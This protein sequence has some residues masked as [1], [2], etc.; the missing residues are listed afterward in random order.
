M[1]QSAAPVVHD[2]S[3]ALLVTSL[4]VQGG[5]AAIGDEKTAFVRIVMSGVRLENMRLSSDTTPKRQAAVLKL[6]VADELTTSLREIM[7]LWARSTPTPVVPAR[8]MWSWTSDSPPG[9]DILVT[10]VRAG[11]EEVRTA[12]HTTPIVRLDF[13]G[14]LLKALTSD[15]PPIRVPSAVFTVPRHVQSLISSLKKCSAALKDPPELRFLG[16]SVPDL[17]APPGSFQPAWQQLGA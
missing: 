8:G 10:K 6:G 4:S 5:E 9:D 7:S 12:E 2:A 13:V 3:P 15:V 11:G 17:E 1:G 14:T 16:F